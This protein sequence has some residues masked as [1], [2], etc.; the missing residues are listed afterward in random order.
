MVNG[1]QELI[2]IHQIVKWISWIILTIEW[3]YSNAT[4]VGRDATPFEYL[5]MQ[6][7]ALCQRYYWEWG[8]ESNSSNACRWVGSGN[9]KPP[10][11]WIL[12]PHEM[13][14][15]QLHQDIVVVLMFIKEVVLSPN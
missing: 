13:R 3:G 14:A 12:F 9:G 6:T 1:I 4:E 5:P 8:N 11:F 7:D 10:H 15:Q 2:I